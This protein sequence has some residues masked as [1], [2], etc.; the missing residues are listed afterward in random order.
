MCTSPAPLLAVISLSL[1][2]WVHGE[3]Q[4]PPLAALFVD[5]LGWHLAG[6]QPQGSDARD[7]GHAATLW[8]VSAGEDLSLKPC[9]LVTLLV[10]RGN[11]S[12][13]SW[14]W[15]QIP[16][17]DRSVCVCVCARARAC[18][19]L[20]SYVSMSAKDEVNRGRW[21]ESIQCLFADQYDTAAGTELAHTQTPRPRGP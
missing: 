8:R 18:A 14:K 4:R 20:S 12:S 13:V 15:N 7:V 11:L 1:S 5:G 2:P 6:R 10:Y 9:S 19:R 3:E 17:V 16:M 21:K